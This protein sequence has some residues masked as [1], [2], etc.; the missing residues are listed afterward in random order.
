M[1]RSIA[2]RRLVGLL[3]AALFLASCGTPAAPTASGSDTA[4]APTAAPASGGQP[5]YKIALVLGQLSDSFYT[6]MQCGAQEAAS[7]FGDV[8]LT[9]QGPAKW[10]ASLQTPIVNA[11]TANQ[12]QAIIIAVNDGK[13]M[14]APLKAANDAGIKI[15]SVDTKLEDPAFVVTNIASD[16]KA[17]GAEA[18][19]TLAQ[20]VGD[21]GV[22]LTPAIRAGVSTAGERVQGFV[23][24]M[25]AN[26]PSIEVVYLG[27]AEDTAD[28][29]VAA[30]NAA[31]VAHP[32]LAGIFS[33][34]N[35]QS[36]AAATAIRG[37]PADRQQVVKVVSFDAG[38]A[39]V[40]SLKAD[41]LQAL[42][43]QKPAEMGAL[44]VEM[45]RKALRGEQVESAIP[46]G[47]VGITKDTI[48]SPD[49]SRYVYKSNC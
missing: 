16:N 20:L 3:G 1:V 26:H 33:I 46:T 21:K 6:S 32:D 13:A 37:L 28:S 48:D 8:D 22:V 40:K 45:A 49:F 25:K 10:D 41:Q 14:Y 34:A 23:D 15:V 29:Q 35:N 17:L 38:E 24:E 9:V 5:R 27:Q 36:E 42:I 43:A 18:A 47:G 2:H 12:V 30:F 11:L 19:K 39:L 7:K 4:S 31:F 44:A